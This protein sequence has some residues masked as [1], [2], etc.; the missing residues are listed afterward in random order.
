MG[1][2]TKV[3]STKNA[4]NLRKKGAM[5]TSDNE[6]GHNVKKS[7]NKIPSKANKN[8]TLDDDE[9]SIK[10]ESETKPIYNQQTK[11]TLI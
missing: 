3:P 2:P 11:G 4:F 10:N 6:D 8:F 7:V 1:A 9:I 5:P